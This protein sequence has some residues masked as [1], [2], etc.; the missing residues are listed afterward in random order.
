MGTIS[1]PSGVS[2]NVSASDAAINNVPNLRNFLSKSLDVATKAK[3]PIAQAEKILNKQITTIA[4]N[5]QRYTPAAIQQCTVNLDKAV[6]NTP[7]IDVLENLTNTGYMPPD[8]TTYQEALLE[9]VQSGTAQI[10]PVFTDKNGVVGEGRLHFPGEESFNS[11]FRGAPD[12]SVGLPVRRENSAGRG[13]NRVWNPESGFDSAVALYGG[14]EG[15]LMDINNLQVGADNKVQPAQNI[16]SIVDIH[17]SGG[18]TALSQLAGSLAFS[19]LA[20]GLGSVIGD[21]LGA[22]GIAVSNEAATAIA[23]AGINI[24]GGEDPTTAIR[25]A[26]TGAIIDTG[27]ANV[28]SEIEK[29]VQAMSDD[30]YMALL[31]GG[32][33]G[34]AFSSAAKVA[35]KGGSSQDI[36]NA[37]VAGA[38]GSGVATE[39]DS[40]AIG[41]AVA[42]GLTGGATGAAM[43]A[44]TAL[45]TE[46]A[47]GGATTTPGGVPL[48]PGGKV[49]VTWSVDQTG[50]ALVQ[51]QDGTTEVVKVDPSVQPGTSVSVDPN[52][53]I[54]TVTAGA[55]FAGAGTQV[56]GG[57]SAMQAGGAGSGTYYD[58]QGRLIVPS[59]GESETGGGAGA[60]SAADFGLPTATPGGQP[61]SAVP[62]VSVEGEAA[63]GAATPSGAAGLAGGGAESG[64]AGGLPTAGTPAIIS[65]TPTF[66][67]IQYGFPTP[68]PPA[69]ISNIGPD[70]A[71]KEAAPQGKP[72][73]D[74]IS[75]TKDTAAGKV[76]FGGATGVAIDES[77]L[78]TGATEGGTLP[79]VT[80]TAPPLGD[81]TLVSDEPPEKT[82][83]EPGATKEPAPYLISGGIS[84]RMK[85]RA[86]SKALS[87]LV[88][89]PFER[90]LITSGLTSYRGAGEIESPETGG[91]RT[92]AWNEASL[93]LKDALGI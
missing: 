76:P 80:V 34:S 33:I 60:P 64:A 29:G 38:T 46:A 74:Q 9:A 12:G 82:A 41:Q 3:K 35:A 73:P 68:N 49:G 40:R 25:N 79:E 10:T 23:R 84:P 62:T 26:I 77:G 87:T 7:N 39:T 66:E 28:A 53:N 31:I 6:Q 11:P 59:P 43:G 20:P 78:P 44:A 5:P 13:D 19:Y 85:A 83:E 75:G 24:A 21:S 71:I 91:K 27:S 32:A 45:G 30:K 47:K 72:I 92:T 15:T 93:R 18:P 4:T 81:E 1:T 37:A 22:A 2:C 54:A 65:S 67:Q 63:G 61:I 51:Y 57:S 56:A 42:G 69:F 14:Q 50:N 88:Q 48:P 70:L 58:T 17:A 90:S 8:A 86:P 89:T 16:N 52:T 55:P 36:L